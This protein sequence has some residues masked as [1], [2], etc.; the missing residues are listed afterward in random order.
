M[1]QGLLGGVWRDTAATP[2]KLQD[3]E[4][5]CCDTCSA[6]HVA[7]QGSPHTCATMRERKWEGESPC[8]T[9]KRGGEKGQKGKESQEKS[10]KKFG[11][12]SL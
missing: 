7:R 2:E 8:I 10:K 1:R 3:S 5:I 11:C 12:H 6:T 9:G 4:E